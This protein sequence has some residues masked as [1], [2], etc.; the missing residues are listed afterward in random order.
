MSKPSGFHVRHDLQPS[1]TNELLILLRSSTT[2]QTENDLQKAAEE[3]GYRLRHRK[4]Y[5]KL[6]ITLDE[7]GIVTEHQKKFRLTDAGQIITN[8]AVY[9]RDLLAEF[10]HFLY[11]VGWDEN[12]EQ[13]SSWSYKTVCEI[14]WNTAPCHID[15]DR[16]VNL[17]TQEALSKFQDNRVS[18]STSSVAGILNWVTELTPFCIVNGNDGLQYFSRRPYCPI[19]AFVLALNHIYCRY[20]TSKQAYIPITQDFKN[21]VC[22]ICLIATE[23]F[24]DML[25]QAE[26][27]FSS[28]QVRHERGE[29]VAIS[30]F[31]WI[32][33]G[34]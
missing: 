26:S 32:S 20:K 1:L 27:C 18:F 33:L 14:L 12:Q 2:G 13:R 25:A 9:Q 17:I 23:S 19:E 15:R 28:I 4:D 30:N 5:G 21:Q 10:I 7:L 8:I 34:S 22:K 24:D 6:L 31:S 11:M 3:R 29:R 16:L